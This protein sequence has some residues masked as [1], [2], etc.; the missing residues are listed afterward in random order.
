M[1]GTLP[2]GPC[3][4]MIISRSLRRMRSVSDKSC[5]ENQNTHFMFSNFFRKPLPLWDNVERYG[6]ARQATDE[7]VIRRMRFACWITEATSTHSEY[8]TLIAFPLQQLLRENASML[9]LYVLA[10]LVT[11]RFSLLQSIKSGHDRFL[12][13]LSSSL[14]TN[15]PTIWR[16]RLQGLH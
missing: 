13:R 6:K 9:R 8:V 10:C 14:C 15:Y 11:F 2:W 7:N 3:V 12:S 1:K 4:F 16:Y 5:R